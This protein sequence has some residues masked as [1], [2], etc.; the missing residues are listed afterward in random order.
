MSPPK[1]PETEPDAELSAALAS[2]E[3]EPPGPDLRAA[4][5]ALNA[6]IAQSES[7]GWER[8]R[9]LSTRTRAWLAWG[10]V[11]GVTLLT[12]VATPRVELSA[13]P[14]PRMLLS[15]AVIAVLC[16]ALLVPALGSWH[17]PALTP[18][19]ALGWV[20]GAWLA[21]V[22]LSLLPE[23]HVMLPHTASERGQELRRALGCLGFGFALG[24]PVFMLCRWL[25]R[26]APSSSVAAAAV[27]GLAGNAALQLHC[28]I[29][30]PA[31]LLLGHSTLGLVVL[32]LA[33]PAAL[34]MYLRAR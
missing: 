12:L 19:R 15:L 34:R 3:E 28:P 17:H 1:P 8:V 31:H 21:S 6:R 29:T 30:E 26:G 16:G 14:W 5:A 25:G 9:S 23:A 10:G 7:S 24:L 13:Y 2:T 32:V 20:L 4:L 11:L 33:L 27:A 22:A 18:R